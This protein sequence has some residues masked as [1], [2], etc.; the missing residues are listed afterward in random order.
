[1]EW[2]EGVGGR[3]V[4]GGAQCCG[5]GR[6]LC[7]VSLGTLTRRSWNA[8][9]PEAFAEDRRSGE[10]SAQLDTSG[11]HRLLQIEFRFR[12][13]STTLRLNKRQY[14][15]EKAFHYSIKGRKCLDDLAACAFG[16]KFVV[17]AL[18]HTCN[19]YKY[20]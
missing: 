17:M 20:V 8:H 18:G 11:R 10:W 1:M 5:L 2:D 13:N 7:L 4:Q 9:G 6:L 16:L 3:D 19:V 15:L 12:S 14:D